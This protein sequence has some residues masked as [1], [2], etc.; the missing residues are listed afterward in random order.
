M[1]LQL[2]LIIGVDQPG[3]G[4]LGWSLW[5]IRLQRLVRICKLC[6]IR[7]MVITCPGLQ[8]IVPMVHMSPLAMVT[9]RNIL[10]TY[11]RFHCQVKVHILEI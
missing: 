2:P 10:V 4:L 3:Y 7:G 9:R 1:H 5:Q 6:V 8:W 11:L